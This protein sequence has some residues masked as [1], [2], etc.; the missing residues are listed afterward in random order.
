MVEEGTEPGSDPD[1]RGRRPLWLDRQA[2]PERDELRGAF[3]WRLSSK[4][5]E[6]IRGVYRR[7]DIVIIS[8][9]SWSP[10]AIHPL[11]VFAVRLGDGIV[12]S[13]VSWTGEQL[14]LMN[15]AVAPPAILR[16]KGLNELRELIVGRV[17]VAVQRFR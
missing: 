10:E 3:A 14:V 12:L 16:A 17:I 1:A 6:R 2:L 11:M 7:G 13:R 8:P 15:S 4:G 5:T 9:E